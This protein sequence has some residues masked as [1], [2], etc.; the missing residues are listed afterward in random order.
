MT[1][2]LSANPSDLD[3]DVL[4]GVYDEFTMV[5]QPQSTTEKPGT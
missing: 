1:G 2:F 4:G 5:S 3:V